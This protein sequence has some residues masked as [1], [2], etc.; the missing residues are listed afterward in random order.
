MLDMFE[1][2]QRIQFGRM[3]SGPSTSWPSFTLEGHFHRNNAPDFS[4]T[5][6]ALV[7]GFANR[8]LARVRHFV[9]EP[10]FFLYCLQIDMKIIILAT[11]P[12]ASERQFHEARNTN[13]SR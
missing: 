1:I 10:V 7:D 12:S 3:G 9:D 11:R 5:I 8:T 4:T 6:V 13:R 2:K